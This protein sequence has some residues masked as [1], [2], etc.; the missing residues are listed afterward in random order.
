MSARSR[1]TPWFREPGERFAR[2]TSPPDCAV[3]RAP[4]SSYLVDLGDDRHL[5]VVVSWHI[6][7]N[8]A[9]CHN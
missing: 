9:V 7:V 3:I 4:S 8:P 5:T 6:E 1:S 2:E